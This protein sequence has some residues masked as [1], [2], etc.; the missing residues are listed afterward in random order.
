M[1]DMAAKQWL[2]T[3][4]VMLVFWLSMNLHAINV[5]LWQT[6]AA[7]LQRG[8]GNIW[9]SPAIYWFCMPVMMLISGRKRA[10]TIVPTTTARKT[11]ITGSSREVRPVTALSTSSS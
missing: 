5:H 11:I 2:L 10:M 6:S 1:A 3:P 8:A 4:Q 7:L 9:N